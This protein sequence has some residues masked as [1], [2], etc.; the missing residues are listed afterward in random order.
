MEVLL[1][2]GG[3]EEVFVSPQELPVDYAAAVELLCER[4]IFFLL[5]RVL[6]DKFSEDVIET[7][8]LESLLVEEGIDPTSGH[9]YINT[10]GN[11]RKLGRSPTRYGGRGGYGTAVIFLLRL[12]LNIIYTSLC[13]QHEGT[14]IPSVTMFPVSRG[15]VTREVVKTI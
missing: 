14:S 6:N 1:G 3:K 9:F 12:I 13:T 11:V 4:G 7:M 5:E 8:N 15:R 10:V 2:Q